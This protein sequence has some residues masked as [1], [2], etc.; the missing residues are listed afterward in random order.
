MQIFIK[1]FCKTSAYGI[2][3]VKTGKKKN[4]AEMPRSFVFF[5]YR[6]RLLSFS[7]TGSFW[8]FSRLVSSRFVSWLHCRL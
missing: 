3:L 7:G 2:I 4:G 1:L 8:L 5:R 6:G